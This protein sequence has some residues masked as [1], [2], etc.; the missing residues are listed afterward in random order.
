ML[1]KLLSM[2]IDLISHEKM[3]AVELASKLEI[4]IRTVYR[5]IDELSAAGIP[6]YCKR[7]NGGGIMV[8][9]E[10]RLPA[11]F[12]NRD[13]LDV[14]IAALSSSD[15]KDMKTAESARNKLITMKDRRPAEETKYY[16]ENYVVDNSDAESDVSLSNKI[17][18]VIDAKRARKTMRI[19]YHD[20]H[21]ETTTR[22]IDPYYLVYHDGGWYV[23]AFCHLRRQ[24]RL[25]KIARIT[26]MTLTG[27]VFLPESKGKKTYTFQM[28]PKAGKVQIT[29][30]ITPEG[31]Y[32]AEDWLGVEN[33]KP[34]DDGVNYVASGCVPDDAATYAKIVKFG[35]NASVISPSSLKQ[36]I[37]K[38]C[39]EFMAANK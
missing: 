8:G 5:Y 3:T 35:K 22:D 37:L 9:R 38:M 23:H 25:F 14:A 29:L 6:V 1:D 17:N 4:S 13:E 32:D 7:G 15:M 19:C 24:M 20:Y 34:S 39:E 28:K 31:R 16:N 2:T 33:V 30:K 26:H 27:G 36:S 12:L 18:A 10:F 21:G 11:M